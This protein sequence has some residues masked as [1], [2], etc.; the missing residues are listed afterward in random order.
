MA[1]LVFSKAE[2]HRVTSEKPR[3][4]HSHLYD[5]EE[6]KAGF[7]GVEANGLAKISVYPLGDL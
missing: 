4:I 5:K 2:E 3:P 6:R 1:D 7:G